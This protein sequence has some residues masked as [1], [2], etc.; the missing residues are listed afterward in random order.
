MDFILRKIFILKEKYVFVRLRLFRRKSLLLMKRGHLYRRNWGNI[1]DFRRESQFLPL[2]N[3]RISL[4]N[5]EDIPT[6]RANASVC[7]RSYFQTKPIC[8]KNLFSQFI[9][10]KS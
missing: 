2:N 1:T 5:V 7:G 10:K 6:L 9:T 4:G 8:L 3:Q